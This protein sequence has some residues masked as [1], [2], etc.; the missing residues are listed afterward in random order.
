MTQASGNEEIAEELS[1][2][3]HLLFGKSKDYKEGNPS[4]GL[5][6]LAIMEVF[7]AKDTAHQLALKEAVEALEKTGNVIGGPTM[8]YAS[9]RTQINELQRMIGEGN[10]IIREALSKLRERNS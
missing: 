10:K 7:H 3:I 4:G 1:K 2:D 9:E 8:G 6:A 5:V